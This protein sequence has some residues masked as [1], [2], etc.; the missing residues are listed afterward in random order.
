[1]LKLLATTAVLLFLTTQCVDSAVADITEIIGD[2]DVILKV[3]CSTNWW[4]GSGLLV[5]T[6]T[7]VAYHRHATY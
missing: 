2:T 7:A 4:T 3:G 1:M 6:G 5:T